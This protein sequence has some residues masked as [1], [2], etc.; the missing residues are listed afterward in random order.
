MDQMHDALVGHK[1][2]RFDF[3][4]LFFVTCKHTVAPTYLVPALTNARRREQTD[5]HWGIRDRLPSINVHKK[6]AAR[7]FKARL[8]PCPFVAAAVGFIVQL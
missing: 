1:A 4:L 2:V 3:F 6:T 5:Y 8:V 7:R